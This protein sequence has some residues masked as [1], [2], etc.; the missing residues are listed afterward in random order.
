M[1]VFVWLFISLLIK[2]RWYLACKLHLMW[3]DE[4]SATRLDLTIGPYISFLWHVN[5]NKQTNVTL[6][7]RW[8]SCSYSPYF[9]NKCRPLFFKITSVIF[10]LSQNFNSNAWMLMW[11]KPRVK[12]S[13]LKLFFKQYLISSCLTLIS[14]LLCGWDVECLDNYHYGNSYIVA[15][16]I[17]S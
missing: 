9:I 2:F 17:Y 3:N 4:N 15:I 14:N 7:I 5:D 13:N 8:P 1:F 10:A 16:Y 11:V 12:S 6:S